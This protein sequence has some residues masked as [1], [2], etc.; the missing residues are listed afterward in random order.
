MEKISAEYLRNYKS[1][2]DN[3]RKINPI[4]IAIARYKE[5]ILSSA[6]NGGKQFNITDVSDSELQ[7]IKEKLKEIFTDVSME[8]QDYSHPIMPKMQKRLNISW[9]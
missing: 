9:A 7:L 2:Y 6:R 8:I 1:F 5:M 3:E 4:G